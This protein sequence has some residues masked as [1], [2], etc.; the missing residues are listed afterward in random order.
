MIVDR[1]NPKAICFCGR[2]LRIDGANELCNAGDWL[3]AVWQI[4]TVQQ[5]WAEQD[6]TAEQ[7]ERKEIEE[8]WPI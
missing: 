1:A 6:V 5:A 3:C 4:M 7:R 2:V 8:T